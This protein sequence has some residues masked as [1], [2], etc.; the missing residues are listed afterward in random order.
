MIQR[1]QT[2]WLLL[3]SATIFL[4]LQFPFYSGT[5]S[6]DNATHYLNA[7]D[8][9]ILLVITSLLGSAIFIAI[10]L[11]KKRP[12]QFRICLTAIFSELLVLF[13]YYRQIQLYSKGILA[14]SAIF[15]LLFL[16]FL[17]LAM[18]G[19]HKDDKLIR[20]SNRLR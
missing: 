13:L 1:I 7:T 9:F 18:R 6:A 2:I 8:N 10:F 3:A 5:L 4:T 19:I 14:W 15:H 16:F 20:E 11:F 17:I 12:I